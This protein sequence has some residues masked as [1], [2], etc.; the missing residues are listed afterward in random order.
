[1]LDNPI[2]TAGQRASLLSN[3]S[4]EMVRLIDRELADLTQARGAKLEDV[5]RLMK[6]IVDTNFDAIFTVRPDGKVEN[7]NRAAQ[8]MFGLP[9]DGRFVDPIDTF[10]PGFRN[11][12]DVGSEDYCVG[13]GHRE[14]L[15]VSLDGLGFP[16]EISISYARDFDD[17]IWIVVV[18]DISRHKEQQRQLEHQALHDALTGLPNRVLLNNRL[19]HALT[20]A[21]RTD[22]P[23]ALLLLDLDEFKEVNDTLGHHVGDLLLQEIGK[24][25]T[26]PVR[27]SDTVARLGG[28]EF[29]I[30]LPS[31]TSREKAVEIA[32]RVREMVI[33]PMPL[34]DNLV[35]EVGGSVGV[36]MVPDHGYDAAKLMQCADVA[37]YKAKEGAEKVVVYDPSHD[38]NNIRQLTLSGEL[39]K[40]IEGGNLYFEFQPKL[41]LNSREIVSVEALARWSHKRLGQV[42]PDDFIAQAER[43]G[44]IRELTRW[45]L[46]RAFHHAA[47]WRNNR[48]NI[49]IA[50]N[51]SPKMVHDEDLIDSI[52]SRLISEGLDASTFTF[53]ITE[54]A[55]FIDPE[56]ALA[57]IKRL[58]ESGAQISIDDFGTGYSSL[59]YLQKLE[60]DEIKIDR[61]FVQSMLENPS[62]QVIVKSTIDLAHNLGL[63]VVAEGVESEAHLDMLHDMSCDI[64]QGFFIGRPMMDERFQSWLAH[65]PWRARA[66]TG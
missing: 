6:R 23:M 5:S 59:S 32:T 19:E 38:L 8:R 12:T 21:R 45:S 14:S 51:V 18:R 57:N 61:S 58:S 20:L 2:A 64:A 33:Q 47:E 48:Q 7:S 29:A 46:D 10:L 42:P 66:A 34:L 53:E 44:L 49:Q 39:R 24:R 43:S 63:K 22:E 3:Y 37:M 52:I 26:R 36:A 15:G 17:G 62:D 50:I 41:D 9:G 55:I 54:G 31:A 1:M 35:I 11:F 13:K 30:L 4:N 40:A 56:R 16:V 65:A 27:D 25:L 60:A 28:D